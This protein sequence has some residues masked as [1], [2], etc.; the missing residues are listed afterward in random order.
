MGGFGFNYSGGFGWTNG[1]GLTLPPLVLWPLGFS[2]L[3]QRTIENP[4]VKI[5]FL[6]LC[7]EMIILPL[8]E[9]LVL[10]FM[11]EKILWPHSV[12]YVEAMAAM[13]ALSFV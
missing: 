5:M 2:K 7:H 9:G 4:T 8:N 12:A 11:V 1:F 3:F 6:T 13:R 10:A